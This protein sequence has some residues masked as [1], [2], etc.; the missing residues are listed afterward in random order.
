MQIQAVAARAATY[1]PVRAALAV[2]AF[3]FWVL[4]IAIGVLWLAGTWVFAAVRTGI[5]DA[6]ARAVDGE[7]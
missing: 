7:T 4:G 2:L 3:P 1:D 5:S 6:R